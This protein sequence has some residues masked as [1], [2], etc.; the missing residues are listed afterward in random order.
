MTALN[1]RLCALAFFA[2]SLEKAVCFTRGHQSHPSSA[3]Q[4]QAYDR[5]A[6]EEPAY[7]CS[8]SRSAFIS[9]LFVAPLMA[10]TNDAGA[11]ET[12]SSNKGIQSSV[13]PFTSTKET[14][15]EAISGVIAG[16][17]LTVTK[18]IVKYPLDTA[19]VRLQMPNS[20]YSIQ[21]PSELFNG[22]FRGVLF[23]LLVNI[24]A[25]AVFFGVKDACKSVLKQQS[26]LPKW[27]A[28]CI[29]VAFAQVPY[30]MV[31][32]PS[33]VVKTRQ[34]ACVVGFGPDVTDLEAYK[35]IYNETKGTASFY[36]GYWENILY[37]YP[38][39]LIKFVTYD[40]LSGGRQSLSPAEGAIVGAASTAVA[41]FLTTPLDVVRNRIMV[42]NITSADVNA[43]KH[44]Q[45]S[46]FE[47]L[48]QLQ[49]NEGLSGLFAGAIPR[50]CK[51]LVSGAVQFAT[52]E[53]TKRQITGAF[54]GP[55]NQ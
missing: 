30:W 37:A 8:V 1:D 25:G 41:Q 36:L 27:F 18:T 42:R 7:S 43:L 40:C 39:D 31:R 10:L 46:Y 3:G 13:A 26:D 38:A 24:P 53:E 12:T 4:L 14:L 45:L 11:T 50:V 55:N 33:E 49:Q 34:Q 22:S 21:K 54:R 17:A 2:L 51:A 19:S 44:H 35:T 20:A 15:E 23:P 32:N 52:Y 47:T 16:S 28:T 9:S 5:E 29:A 48:V 6:I